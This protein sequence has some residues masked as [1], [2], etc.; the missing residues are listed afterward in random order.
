LRAEGPMHSLGH[1]YRTPD[2]LH[3]GGRP[4]HPKWS[5]DSM[6][7]PHCHRVWD[8]VKSWGRRCLYCGALLL[9]IISTS[10]ALPRGPQSQPEPP[11]W[12]YVGAPTVYTN[13][14]SVTSTVSF[15][16]RTT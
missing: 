7:C 11:D 14:A 2:F 8:G 1:L 16:K 10:P 15:D 13:T 12:I 4:D 9:T 5:V 6:I 3:P